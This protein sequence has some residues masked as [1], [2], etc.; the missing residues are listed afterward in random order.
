MRDV[1]GNTRPLSY[2]DLYKMT[3]I[4]RRFF[5]F[6]FG[7]ATIILHFCRKICDV[8]RRK[9]SQTHKSMDYVHTRKRQ[10]DGV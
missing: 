6:L 5:V 8:I 10:L 7:S 3:Q 2:V 1:W 9:M 4:S